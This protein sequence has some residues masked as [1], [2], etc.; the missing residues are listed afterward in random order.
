MIKNIFRTLGFILVIIGACSMD[1]S[2]IIVPAVLILIGMALMVGT[3]IEYIK[4]VAKED[5]MR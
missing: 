5:W 3:S 2:V 1:S 4:E